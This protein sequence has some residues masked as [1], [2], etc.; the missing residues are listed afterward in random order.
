MSVIAD[1]LENPAPLILTVD[2]LV[3]VS[4]DL[5]LD[6]IL[7]GGLAIDPTTVD[8]P[9]A[10]RSLMARGLVVASED[11][12]VGL[13]SDVDLL[14]SLVADPMLVVTMR[15]ES[16][17]VAYAWT[18][19]TDGFIGVQQQVDSSGLIVWMP[20]KLDETLDLVIGALGPE[21]IDSAGVGSFESTSALLAAA[22]QMASQVGQQQG[23]ATSSVAERTYVHGLG[24]GRGTSM[25]SVLNRSV[26]PPQRHELIWTHLGES[27]YWTLDI[28]DLDQPDADVPVTVTNRNGAEVFRL[29]AMLFPID[30]TALSG[31]NT[32]GEQSP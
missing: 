31:L 30:E 8:S 6:P 20:F 10:R 25:I 24:D 26:E 21:N 13:R 9:A 3:T 16:P 12:E 28:A 15:R 17:D 23:S 14:V 32:E 27:G 22:D 5:G 29:L 18:L 19:F 1:L 4:A 7:D 11:G 2:E